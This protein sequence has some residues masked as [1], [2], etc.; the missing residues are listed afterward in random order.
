MITKGLC[1]LR[2]SNTGKSRVCGTVYRTLVGG[3]NQ[4]AAESRDGSKRARVRLAAQ[5]SKGVILLFT[6][7]ACRVDLFL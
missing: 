3:V 4:C 1:V 2:D 6:G 5:P 7:E